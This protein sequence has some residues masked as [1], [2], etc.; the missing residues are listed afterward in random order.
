MGS[1]KF[2]DAMSIPFKLDK[3]HVEHLESFV[4]LSKEGGEL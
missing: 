2:Y 1:F 3:P 4:L